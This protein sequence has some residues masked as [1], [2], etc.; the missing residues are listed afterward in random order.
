MILQ[1]AIFHILVGV[2]LHLTSLYELKKYDHDLA[3]SIPRTFYCHKKENIF[4]LGRNSRQMCLTYLCIFRTILN[5]L[6]CYLQVFSSC[7]L[8]RGVINMVTFDY[9]YNENLSTDYD[10]NLLW[11]RQGHWHHWLDIVLSYR[12]MMRKL[13][14]RCFSWYIIQK[15]I[16]IQNILDSTF[17]E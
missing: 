17:Y 4:I 12:T 5:C 2:F 9:T 1:N 6:I 8:I 3:I 10:A 16:T 13:A 14:I 7:P 15:F 11:G